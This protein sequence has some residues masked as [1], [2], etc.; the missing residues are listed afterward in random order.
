MAYNNQDRSVR[1]KY[2]QR[3]L[4]QAS[5]TQQK[6][7][8]LVRA[9]LARAEQQL[10]SLFVQHQLDS[11][12]F[13]NNEGSVLSCIGGVPEL[14]VPFGTNQQGVPQGA[15][16]IHLCGQE[17]LL[18]NSAYAFEQGTQLRVIPQI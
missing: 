17:Q 6:D 15:T 4:A 16:F 2:G 11:L 7:E 8:Q 18:V 5:Q 1:A 3:L 13:L 10:T 9:M 14:S 12:V